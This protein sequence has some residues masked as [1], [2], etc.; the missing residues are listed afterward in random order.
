M[1]RHSGN[2]GQKREMDGNR[3]MERRREVRVEETE[4]RERRETEKRE[5]GAGR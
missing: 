3:E 4:E 2:E 5:V 1:G